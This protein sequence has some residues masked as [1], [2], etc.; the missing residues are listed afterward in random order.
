MSVGPHA[1]GP[2]AIFMASPLSLQFCWEGTVT[3]PYRNEMPYSW[4][5]LNK[6]CFSYYLLLN[7]EGIKT[8]RDELKSHGK[9]PTR[10]CTRKCLGGKNRHA[11]VKFKGLWPA[12]VLQ[13]EL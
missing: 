6:N 2:G 8:N 5:T 11:T 7:K 12:M 4:L 3:I 13:G 10:T 1:T 9:T